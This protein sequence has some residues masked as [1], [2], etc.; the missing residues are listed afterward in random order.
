MVNDRMRKKIREKKAEIMQLLRFEGTQS[1][2]ERA[3]KLTLERVELVK[4]LDI[5]SKL[6]IELINVFI[7]ASKFKRRGIPG[8]DPEIYKEEA[9]HYARMFG[10]EMM[11]VY[12]QCINMK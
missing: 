8:P 5:R 4:K 7:L 10:E 2:M 6:V 9:L 1:S 12:N 11:N 3:M